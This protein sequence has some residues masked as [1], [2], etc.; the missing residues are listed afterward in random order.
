[1]RDKKA[2]GRQSIRL[3]GLH[4]ATESKRIRDELRRLRT[5]SGLEEIDREGIIDVFQQKVDAEAKATHLRIGFQLAVGFT[6]L[7]LVSIGIMS[8]FVGSAT[9]E[10]S[11]ESH[12]NN[13]NGR[14]TMVSLTGK[15]VKTAVSESFVSLWALPMIS[16]EA[17]ATMHHL[18]V[19][20]EDGRRTTYDIA[21]AESHLGVARLLTADG[22][23]LTI[24]MLD[25]TLKVSSHGKNYLLTN[26]ATGAS[27]AA[28]VFPGTA[29]GGNVAY[30]PE[31]YTNRKKLA[32]A[33]RVLGAGRELSV[34]V[35]V[36]NPS[37]ATF[38]MDSGDV[39]ISDVPVQTTCVAD[40]TIGAPACV[41]SCIASCSCSPD[42]GSYCTCVKQCS[43][44]SCD[45]DT[46]AKMADMING[47][48][49]AG[50]RLRELDEFVRDKLIKY[51]NG[52]HPRKLLWNF[53]CC[54]GG[55]ATSS[56]DGA[57]CHATPS[58]HEEGAGYEL[59]N[60]C[61]THD[62]CLAG[63]G[64]T[65]CTGCRGNCDSQLAVSAARAGCGNGKWWGSYRWSAS[66]AGLRPLLIAAM[67]LRPNEWLL[68]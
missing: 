6:V 47:Q 56:V 37:F 8:Y 50:R 18:S 49:G 12:I 40:D 19:N 27:A 36:S 22:S 25:Q 17:L 43:T 23:V 15:T 62:S 38:G 35:A 34:A 64:N 58:L 4:S 16:T 13:I 7:L 42:E 30:S 53:G 1:M 28:W 45:A 26:N 65:R 3:S 59:S 9:I 44:A 41:D 20:F 33:G 39:T 67:L 60:A 48:C 61:K 29:A 46:Q 57:D 14:S 32:G 52:E 24:D 51:K 63:C 66:C 55:L 5:N 10:A 54:S 2:A 21:S 31:E 68:C 11:K